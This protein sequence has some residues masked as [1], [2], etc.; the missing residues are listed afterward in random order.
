MNRSGKTIFTAPKPIDLSTVQRQGYTSLD[1]ELQDDEAT[2]DDAR[3]LVFEAEEEETVQ[4]N[5]LPRS[6]Q[7]EDLWSRL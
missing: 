3:E 2:P 6:S 4:G 7:D 5:S 1:S